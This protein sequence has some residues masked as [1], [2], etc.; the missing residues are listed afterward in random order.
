MEQCHKKQIE[1]IMDGM[2]CPK[3]FVYYKSGF[4][5]GCQEIADVSR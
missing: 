1:E 2:V 5:E 3:D 4:K